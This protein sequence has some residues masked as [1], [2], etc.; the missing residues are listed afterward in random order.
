MDRRFGVGSGWLVV[1]AALG[2]SA[3]FIWG[4][5]ATWMEPGKAAA[6]K[7]LTVAPLLPPEAA[8]PTPT[9]LR[10][11]AISQRQPLYCIENRGQVDKRVR[12]YAQGPGHALAFTRRGLTLTSSRTPAPPSPQELLLGHQPR[13]APGPAARVDL[14]PVGMRQGATPEAVEPQPGK[15]NYLIG[16]DPKQWRTDLNTYQ[17]VLYREAYPGIDLKLYSR[18]RQLE[19]DVIVK[20]GAD[21]NRVRFAYT[22]AEKLTV[23]PAGD[24]AVTLPGG[25]ELVQKKPVVYQEINGVTVAREGKFRLHGG[26]ARLVYGFQVAAYDRQHP[27]IIDPVLGYSVYLGGGGDEGGPGGCLAVDRYGNAYITGFTTSKDLLLP[28]IPF[29]QPVS[30]GASDVFIAKLGVS[31]TLIYA[32]Y[33]GGTSDDSGQG[34]AVDYYG[35]AYVT[36]YTASDNFPTKTPLSGQS[37]FKGEWDVFVT[38]LN[39]QGNG[40]VWSTF[41][42]VGP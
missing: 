42:G 32:T 29:Y 10:A 8:G 28:G 35:N 26:E 38:K 9:R 22:G 16:N 13:P 7:G 33:L 17:A 2:I 34:M 39:P 40:L 23:T 3:F 37:A 14:T 4:L 30:G 18:G 31:G 1:V 12:Y 5:S 20:A 19:Y 27:L 24:L 25:G 41:L 15:V 11:E 6:V 21:P 36:G